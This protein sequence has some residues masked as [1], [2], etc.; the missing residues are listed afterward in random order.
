MVESIP[1]EVKW[2]WVMQ[3]LKQPVGR[4]LFDEIDM[5]IDSYPVFFPWEHK[6]KSIPNE[7]HDAYFREKN[8]G[9]DKPLDFSR[10][11]S[12]Y[13]APIV[14]TAQDMSKSHLDI[15]QDIFDLEEAYKQK[16]IIK[17]KEDKVLW[18]K[19]YKKYKLKY[20]E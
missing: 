3:Q 18:D 11:S 19:Y 8:P 6:Y 16:A 9:W 20:R 1:V 15:L 13:G 7:V 17:E 12:I 14:L 2:V 10:Q 4:K 5:I